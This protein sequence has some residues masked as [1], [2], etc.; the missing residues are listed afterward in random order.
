MRFFDSMAVYGNNLDLCL[1]WF[2]KSSY[3]LTIQLVCQ[4]PKSKHLASLFKV[5]EV[6]IVDICIMEGYRVHWRVCITFDAG[7]EEDE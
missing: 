4:F 1:A 6:V 3:R 7:R 2:S 5:V